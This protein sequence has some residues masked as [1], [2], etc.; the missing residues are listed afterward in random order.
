MNDM[1]GI[2]EY[3]ALSG[4]RFRGVATSQGYTLRS[5]IKPFQGYTSAQPR[6]VGI[7]NRIKNQ[8]A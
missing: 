1:C 6:S 7:I 8:K 3:V 2:K 4:L 5:H